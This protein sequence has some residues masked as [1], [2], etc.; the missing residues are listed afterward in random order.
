VTVRAWLLTIV[1]ALGAASTLLAQGGSNYSAYGLGDVR[2]NHG[3]LYDAVAGTSI[4]LPTTHGIN[5]VNPS[6]LGMSPTS[7]LQIGYHFNQYYINTEQTSLWQNNGELDGAL[8]LF[9]IDTALGA[10]ITFGVTPASS[11]NYSVTR[12]LVIDVDGTTVTGRSNQIGEGGVTTIV[13]GGSFRPMKWLHVG[14]LGSA[15]FGTMTY[16]DEVKIDGDG[17]FNAKGQS[18]YNLNGGFVR[19]GLYSNITDNFN[20]GLIASIGTSSDV[21]KR[22]RLSGFNSVSISFDTTWSDEYTTQLPLTLGLGFSYTRGR[23]I[24]ALDGEYTDWSSFSMRSNGDAEFRPTLRASFGISRPGVQVSAAPFGDR[25]GFH[26]GLG[27]QQM[28]YSVRG[29]DLDELFLTFGTDFPV[30][31]A[32]MI[33]LAFQVGMRGT[34]SSN[35]LQEYIGRFTATVSIGDTW[36]KP[37]KRE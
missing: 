27:Y 7:R 19:A 23:V 26:G 36:F 10:G 28:Y 3:A 32:A 21:L 35:L 4:A 6:L 16:T 5:L 24:Y 31:G 1:I 8:I 22:N 30:G 34:T 11:I 20:A 18:I 13:L 15:L 17:N 29:Q 14:V 2:H 9:S 25:M 33:D 37:F 12:N